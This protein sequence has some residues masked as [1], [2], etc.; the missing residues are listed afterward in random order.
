MSPILGHLA[1]SLFGFAT[2]LDHRWTLY[3]FLASPDE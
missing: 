3:Q 2:L 1:D